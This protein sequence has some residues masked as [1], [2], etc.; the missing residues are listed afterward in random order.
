MARYSTTTPTQEY[1]IVQDMTLSG[2]QSKVNFCLKEGWRC[3]QGAQ[4]CRMP[5]I[6]FDYFFHQ[7]LVREILCQKTRFWSRI[8]G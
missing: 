3:K 8:I 1:L 4:N 2:L 5:R 7:T 6:E